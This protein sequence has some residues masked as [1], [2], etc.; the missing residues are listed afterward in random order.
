MLFIEEQHNSTLS[1]PDTDVFVLA[2]RRC[3]QLCK[4]T[5]FIT[6][7]G[8]KKRIISLEPVVHVFGKG[9]AALQLYQGSMPSLELTR[10]ADLL[11]RES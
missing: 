8:N 9:M 6:G 7:V 2:I 11:A 4:D 5:Y 3:H 1:P 10:Q